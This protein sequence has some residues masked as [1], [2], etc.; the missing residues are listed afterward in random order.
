MPY[1]PGSKK[2]PVGDGKMSANRL[3]WLRTAIGQFVVMTDDV[4]E[5]TK[6][7]VAEFGPTYRLFL[8]RPGTRPVTYNI[9]ALTHEEFQALKKFMEHLFEIAEPVI[10]ERDRIAEDAFSK[11]DDSFARSYRQVPQ[12]VIREGPVRKDDEGVSERPDDLPSGDESESGRVEDV[13]VS[14]GGVRGA[15]DELASSESPEAVA[16]NY[17]QTTD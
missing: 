13:R 11:G 15:G 17:E 8:P 9:T 3:A 7:T 14:G 10:L 2:Y 12:L 4:T 1:R 16:E 5:E 6:K